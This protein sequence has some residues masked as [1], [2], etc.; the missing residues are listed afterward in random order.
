MTNDCALSLARDLL[1]RSSKLWQFPNG[2]DDA[3]NFCGESNV[4]VI[5]PHS[6]AV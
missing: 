4:R 5:A 1:P 3:Q 6:R 2:A